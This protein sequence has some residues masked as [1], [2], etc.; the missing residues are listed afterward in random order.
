MI[1]K[2]VFIFNN[3]SLP[4]GVSTCWTAK[5]QLPVV[6]PISNSSPYLITLPTGVTSTID[7]LAGS[8]NL[9]R[10]DTS[11]TDPMGRVVRI[12][13]YRTNQ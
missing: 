1:T 11:V 7:P 6:D 2:T 13:G 12:A 3:I 4:E 5:I 10:V 9:V 8:A